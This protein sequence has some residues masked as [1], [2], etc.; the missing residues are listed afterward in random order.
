MKQ[1]AV[2]WCDSRRPA[3]Y[4]VCGAAIA[5]HR[6]VAAAIITLVVSG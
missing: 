3:D 1:T 6:E 5:D 2:I 4:V